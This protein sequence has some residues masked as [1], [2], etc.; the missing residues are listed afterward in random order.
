VVDLDPALG[1]ELFDIAVGDP[2]RRYQ[3]TTTTMTSDGKRKPTEAD[4]EAGARRGRR[5]LMTPVSLIQGG[6]S[7]RNSAP[8]RYPT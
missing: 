5:V 7:E 4:R 3:R 8:E 2:K 6:H 1:E